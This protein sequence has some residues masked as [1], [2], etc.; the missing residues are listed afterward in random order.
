LPPRLAT[1]WSAR[2]G[3]PSV[4]SLLGAKA[5]LPSSVV[6]ASVAAACSSKVGASGGPY[7]S[8]FPPPPQAAASA[9]SPARP[10]GCSVLM[11]ASWG[12]GAVAGRR[13][14]GGWS[15]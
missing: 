15:L 12:A 7:W 6:C 9:R 10:A 13:A 3:A 1:S 11:G 2:P 8:S 14:V 4:G 5:R